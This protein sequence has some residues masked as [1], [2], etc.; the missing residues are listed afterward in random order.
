M[1]SRNNIILMVPH[2]PNYI[3]TFQEDDEKSCYTMI[4]YAKYYLTNRH[5]ILSNQSTNE[6]FELLG[7]EQ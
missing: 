7:Q 4:N 6:R 2:I 1:I 3:K 5:Q